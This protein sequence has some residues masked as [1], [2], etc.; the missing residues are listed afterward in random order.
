MLKAATLWW[1]IVF[2]ELLPFS[3][4]AVAQEPPQPNLA[5]GKPVASSGA[6]WGNLVPAALTDGDP[7]TFSHPL[8]SSGTLDYYFEVDLGG[9]YQL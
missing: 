5:L 4:N 9:S 6:T 7:N 3:S 8:A 1:I 2:A